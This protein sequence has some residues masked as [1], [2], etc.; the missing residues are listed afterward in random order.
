LRS[1]TESRTIV[2]IGRPLPLPSTF[3]HPRLV[4]TM[5]PLGRN[6]R[7]NGPEGHPTRPRERA[8]GQPRHEWAGDRRVNGRRASTRATD[9]PRGG[10]QR[11][12]RRPLTH[13][14]VGV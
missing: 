3:G 11:A 12:K 13:A 10:A 9:R 5:V 2:A 6:R 8:I 14:R 7:R 4:R 1:L